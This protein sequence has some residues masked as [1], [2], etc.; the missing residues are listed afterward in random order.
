MRLEICCCNT[1]RSLQKTNGD[2]NIEGHMLPDPN[3]ARTTDEALAMES[4]NSEINYDC[5]F[6]C[7]LLENRDITS[8]WKIMGA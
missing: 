1:Y 4:A 2:P 3:K 6:L 7:G 5:I 8:N